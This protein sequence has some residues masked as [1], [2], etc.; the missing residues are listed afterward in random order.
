MHVHYA[1][2]ADSKETTN[3]ICRVDTFPKLLLHQ[4]STRG[5]QSAV[6]IKRLGLWEAFSWEKVCVQ[7]KNLAFGLL[8]IGVKPGDTVAVVSS[9]TPEV[10]IKI[11]AI[12]VIGAVP[13]PLHADITGDHLAHALNKTGVQYAFANDQQQV[14]TLLDVMSQCSRLKQIIY[15]SPR[16][17]ANYDKMLVRNI[18]DIIDS[19]SV[20]AKSQP[21]GFFESLVQKTREEDTAFI[22]F[23]SGVSARNP[24]AVP[25]THRN[26]LSVGRYIAK[27]EG[28]N[29]SDEILS[30]MP[31]AMPASL[32]YGY[33]LSHI[34]GLCV[35][36]PESGETVLENLREIGPTLLYAPPHV[37]KYLVSSIYNRIEFSK[38][39]QRWL[40]RRYVEQSPP[41]S[42]KSKSFLRRLH[43]ILGKLMVLSPICNVYGLTHV[44]VAMTGGDAISDKAVG[45]FRALGITVKQIYGSTETSACI[46]I[47]VNGHDET[48]EH[49]AGSVGHAIEGVEIKIGDHDEILCRG[50]NTF[51]GYYNDDEATQKAF[52]GDGWFHTGD[53][54]GLDDHNAL[55]IIDNLNAVG[56]LENGQ[57]FLPKRIENQLKSSPY[58]KNVFVTGGRGDFLSAL[59][60]IDDTT[61][62]NWADQNNIRYTGYV[63]LT[64][65][66]EVENLI[67]KEFQ[68]VNEKFTAA[69]QSQPPVKSFILLGRDFSI[70]ANE[71]TWTNK[72]CRSHLAENV[73]PLIDAIYDKRQVV[74]FN[75]GT[76]EAQMEYR[77]CTV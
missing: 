30:F 77:I 62:S 74:E 21:E 61:I 38:G 50:L 68:E 22:F 35:S 40:Y 9:N 23:S 71:L 67:Q 19:G 54:G 25:L 51:S 49:V 27:T 56:K 14:D 18:R 15:V 57:T 37:Y 34:V 4:A 39:L 8:E 33:V 13:V 32:L 59:V 69:S 76:N 20:Y 41:I 70:Q 11:A 73:R 58:I 17:L 43:D 10:F 63:D 26:L 31:I 29:A 28:I 12:Q 64:A 65:R 3:F 55:H 47:P 66:P 45:L 36:C 72:L 46:T 42:S 48:G 2:Y 75:D 16:G 1:L 52:D 44:R 53:I 7:A 5:G 6:R 24:K 60:V